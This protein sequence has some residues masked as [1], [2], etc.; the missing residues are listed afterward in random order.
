MEA[1]TE[2]DSSFRTWQA[3]ADLV[4]HA[5]PLAKLHFGALARASGLSPRATGDALALLRDDHFCFRRDETL[6]LMDGLEHLAIVGEQG[7][8]LATVILLADLLQTRRE[9]PLLVDAWPEAA[10]QIKAWPATLRAAVANGLVRA[11]EFGLVELESVP[12]A[13]VR[14]TRQREKIAEALLQIARSMR[15]DELLAVAQADRGA[16]V[17][18]HLAALRTV[19]SMRDGILLPDESWYPS[20]VVELSACV[21]QAPGHPGCTAILLLNV[22]QSGDDS[23]WMAFLWPLQAADYCALKPSQRDPILAALR[24]LYETDPEF[25]ADASVDFSPDHKHHKKI[26]GRERWGLTIPVVEEV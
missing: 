23:G 22:L 6:P 12:I 21:P 14:L 1:V 10:R 5:G 9:S 7:F 24:Y 18:R 4:H 11:R 20:E 16:E 26:L 3:V 17:E 8:D 2:H 25:L 13:A 19:I 15:P